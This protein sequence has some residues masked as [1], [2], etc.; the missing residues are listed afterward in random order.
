[1]K[2]TVFFLGLFF[3]M[4]SG[5]SQ[6]S[7]LEAH[8]AASYAVFHTNKSL[9]ADNFDHQR[10]YASRAI[11]AFEKTQAFVEKCGCTEARVNIDLGLENLR[12]AADPEDWDKGRYFTKKA[13]AE[14]QNL[15]A[16]LEMCNS[17]RKQTSFQTDGVL[18]S[19][20]ADDEMEQK[21]KK[22]QQER[23]RL[24]ARQRELEEEQ[25]RLDMQLEQQRKLQEQREME[26]QR[27]LQQQIKLKVKAEQALQNFEK[28]ITELTEVLGCTEAYN[29]IFD[30]YTRAES[31]LESESLTGTQRF[32]T[33][34]A[35]A[36]AR[37]ALNGLEQCVGS[38]K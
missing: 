33:E 6:D 12:K 35:K 38:S 14:A 8:S 10:Y 5:Y 20:I 1:M 22:I 11:E 28:S 21:E 17:G 37:Q 19:S 13:L 30:N 31:A 24:I 16:S 9:K 29:I 4:S 34:K 3:V 25:K 36:I 27:E 15:I 26:R 18:V 23:E 2:T 7:C 32:Y